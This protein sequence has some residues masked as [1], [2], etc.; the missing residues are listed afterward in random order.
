MSDEKDDDKKKKKKP[1]SL[2]MGD[3]AGKVVKKATEEAAPKEIETKEKKEAKK[4]CDCPDCSC[5]PNVDTIPFEE[6]EEEPEIRLNI[7]GKQTKLE[8]IAQGD[9]LS[10]IENVMPMTKK[11]FQKL[12]QI[13][14][15]KYAEKKKL[16]EAVAKFHEDTLKLDLKNKGYSGFPLI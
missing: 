9:F 6:G 4:K 12:Q 10:W 2:N 16:F 5:K 1:L 8:D 15:S 14:F 3:V 11:K 7:R 13:D